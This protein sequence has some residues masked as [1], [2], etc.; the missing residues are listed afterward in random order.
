MLTTAAMR[1]KLNVV[2][3]LVFVTARPVDAQISSEG[4]VRGVIRDAGGGVL[5]GVTVTATSPEVPGTYISL[6]ESD[7]Q[8]RLL[9]LPPGVFDVVA[10]LAGFTKY[11]RQGVEVRA[12][13]N[14]TLDIVLTLG[15]VAESVVV[16]GGS[17]LL[18]TQKPIQAV[19]IAGDFLRELPLSTRRDV[20]D[21]LE[22]T[23]G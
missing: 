4:A 7:G 11:T 18:E 15:N 3:L 12:G 5:P 17:P 21:V 20:T 6:S 23:P 14:L 8:Y 2:A 9:N 22:A 10:E 1:R 16:R 19:N 13:L